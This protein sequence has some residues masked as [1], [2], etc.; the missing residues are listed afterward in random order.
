MVIYRVGNEI[1]EL[2]LQ[3]NFAILTSYKISIQNKKMKQICLFKIKLACN[4]T[5]KV[6]QDFEGYDSASQNLK[7]FKIKLCLYELFN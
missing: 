1:E 5:R 2:N 6:I 3:K 4:Y 7:I